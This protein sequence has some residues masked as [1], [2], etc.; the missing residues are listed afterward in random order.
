M[1]TVACTEIWWLLY[2]ITVV[3]A[4]WYKP[5]LIRIPGP[6]ISCCTPCLGC[7]VHLKVR[8]LRRLHALCAN[9]S[10]SDPCQSS[11]NCG[12]LCSSLTG[13]R[14]PQWLPGF[15]SQTHNLEQFQVERRSCKHQAI[16]RTTSIQPFLIKIRVGSLMLP[17][18]KRDSP[19]SGSLVGMKTWVPSE[20]NLCLSH[21]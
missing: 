20:L 13:I 12:P 16:E 15:D 7:Q 11:P 8:D 6:Q 4:D 18:L 19:K 9:S 21:L 1:L 3:R 14:G 17:T 2:S 10:H 5:L